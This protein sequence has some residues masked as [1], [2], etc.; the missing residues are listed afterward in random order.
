MDLSP[1]SYIFCRNQY[2]EKDL[3][4]LHK[5]GFETF[6]SNE[7]SNIF[8]PMPGYFKRG[9]KLL[10]SYINLSGP[11]FSVPSFK[12]KL[13]SIPSSRFLRPYS[14]NKLERLRLKRIL[15][16]MTLAAK[17]KKGF[18][19]WWHPHNFGENLQININFLEVII[20]HFQFLKNKYSM[21]SLTMSEVAKTI[22]N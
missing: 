1:K 4:E 7:S 10:D 15:D 11:N 6:R 5:A 9:F 12:N 2:E 22:K 18:H 13:V 3:K 14:N 19:L 20:D 16:N 17:N 8:S 21:E